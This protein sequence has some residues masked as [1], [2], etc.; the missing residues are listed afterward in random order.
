MVATISTVNDKNYLPDQT[1]MNKKGQ[2]KEYYSDHGEPEGRFTGTGSRV[3]NLH[4]K[5]IDKDTYDKL[6]D[7]YSPDGF[8]LV[9]NAGKEDRRCAWDVTFSAPKSVSIYWACGTPEQQKDIERAMRQSVQKAIAMMEYKAAITR[10]DKGSKR[11]E[12]PV[13]LI[14]ATFEHC[15][16]RHQ[17]VH[18][19]CHVLVLNVAPRQDGTFGS[20]DSY[21]IYRWIKPLGAV[22]RAELAYQLIKLGYDIEPDGESFR[23]KGVSQE[24][25]DAHSSRSKAI[26]EEL[27]KAGIKS[28]AS[29]EGQHFKT[30]TR[31]SKKDVN[32]RELFQKW[33]TELHEE[34]LTQ[35]YIQSM[36]ASEKAPKAN[37][38]DKDL[39]LAEL[40]EQKATFTEQ[41]LFYLVGVKASHCGV[42]A[43]EAQAFAE[44]ILEN[45][46][47]IS[48]SREEI[49]APHYT[50]QEVLYSEKLMIDDARFLASQHSKVIQEHQALHAIQAAEKQLGFGFDKE[51]QAAI[52]YSLKSGDFCITQGSAGA[53]KTTLMLAVKIAYESN[54]L[55]IVGASIAQKA[56]D[57]LFEETGIP[58]RTIASYIHLIENGQHPLRDIDELAIDEAGLVPSTDLQALLYEARTSHCKLILTGEDRQLD[59]ITK[60][61]ALRYLSRP[62]VVGTQRIETIRRQRQDW[63]REVVTQLRDGHS[64]KALDTLE[65]KEC[66]HWGDTKDEAKAAL[67]Q[68]W[69]HYQKAHPDKQSLV[70][71]QEWKDVKVLSEAIRNIHIN[72]GKV[73]MENIPLECSVANKR[74]HYEF[75]VGDRIKFCRNDTRLLKVSN[76][77]L[78]T[79]KQIES[80]EHDTKL[81]VEIDDNRTVSFLASEYSDEIGINLCH[82]YALTVFS[83]Q[84]TTVNG[85]TFI[86]YSGQMDRANTY[87]AL[88]RHKDE[89]HLYVNKLE[90]TERAKTIKN[91]SM[92]KEELRRTALANL[93]KQDRYASLAIEH[94]EA[95]ERNEPERCQEEELIR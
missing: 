43:L 81:T 15:T 60:G 24:L 69:H 19:H 75:S 79:I 38:L 1:K 90:M 58:S 74:F 82:A 67:I 84:G 62:E 44:L 78:G 36:F 87:V 37:L 92:S 35:D 17:E 68:D 30:S 45:E 7:G 80:V 18:S 89:S 66:L 26:Q 13:G 21:K 47:V 28:S 61:G 86:L 8:K 31:P 50:T 65:E 33:Q 3:F 56:S 83:S 49:Y 4:G 63:A 93:M 12:K 9:Q 25:C 42:N 54:G 94:L 23:L 64:E 55:N 39:I 46:S 29:K 57:N 77:T 41:E 16:N 88:S 85:N 14:M 20:I 59:A 40:T 11:Y 32:R 95:L 72:E 48:L 10:R 76:G 73:G 91:T 22:F 2:S 5:V 70:L 53:G 52:Q 6:M 34:G 27:N 71:A 51:Q